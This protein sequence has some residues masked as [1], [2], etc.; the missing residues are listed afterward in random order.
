MT[1]L[2]QWKP[3]HGFSISLTNY[4]LLGQLAQRTRSREF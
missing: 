3:L 4:E 1:T 2:Y